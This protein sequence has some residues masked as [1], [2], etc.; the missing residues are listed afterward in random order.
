MTEFV[1]AA[2]LAA[3]LPDVL[4]A[5]AAMTTVHMLCTRPAY[6][7]RVFP[8]RISMSRRHGVE[9]DCEMQR[10]WL[11]LADGQPDPRI[12]V[13]ILPLRVLDLIWRD[14]AA[15]V[16]PGDTIIA[17]LNTATASL[18]P[19]S[20]LRVGSAVLRVSDLWNNGCAKWKVRYGAAAHA[21]VSDPAH[22]GHRLRGIL[23]SV[24][25]DGET[26]LGDPITRL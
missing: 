9:D 13:S 19:G 14:R 6:N 23:C 26:G 1:P 11:K 20:L 3:A 24:E 21:W 5:P 18:P 7:Q 15:T 22:E 16:H 2:T 17:D 8:D 10:P 12:H 25:Q 4:D